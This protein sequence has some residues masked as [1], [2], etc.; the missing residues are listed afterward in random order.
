ELVPQGTAIPIEVSRQV[1]VTG[2]GLVAGGV[3]PRRGQDIELTLLGGDAHDP[4]DCEILAELTVH[5]PNEIRSQL[6]IDVRFGDNDG[7]FIID[8]IDPVNSNLLLSQE[9]HSHHRKGLMSEALMERW[10]KDLR[11]LADKGPMT[12]EEL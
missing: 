6:Q 2:P 3:L 9:V 11:T 12:L 5:D 4:R 7:A 8:V 10:R 1:G